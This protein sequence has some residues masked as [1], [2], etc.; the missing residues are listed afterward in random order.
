MIHQFIFASPRPGLTEAEFQRYWLEVHAVRYASKIKQIKKYKIDTRINGHG[1][2][3]KEPRFSGIAEIWIKDEK[4]QIESLQSP[5]FLEGARGDEPRWAA[6]WKTF[7]LD[8]DEHA[9]GELRPQTERAVKLVT[10]YRRKEGLSVDGYRKYVNSAYADR[11]LA[12]PGL[13][14]A[15]FN[16]TRDSW[17]EFGEPR[18]DMIGE[19][20]FDSVEALAD[21][22][23]TPAWQARVADHSNFVAEKHQFS[24]IVR[25]HWIIGPEMRP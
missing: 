16:T 8:T 25:E 20:W 21:A 5:E 23:Q 2:A 7:V 24:M 1:E 9:L 14:Q 19:L 22:M 12:I 18:F 3:E 10:L 6:I 4:D 13:L 11:T 15:Q 17:Y